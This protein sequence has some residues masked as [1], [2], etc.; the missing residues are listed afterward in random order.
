MPSHSNPYKPKSRAHE[1]AI[2][3]KIIHS[4][5]RW[6]QDPLFWYIE[7]FCGLD[8]LDGKKD[9]KEIAREFLSFK[10]SK[11]SAYEKHKWDGD[12]DPYIQLWDALAKGGEDGLG[13]W[14]GVIAGTGVGKTYWAARTVLWFLDVFPNSVVITSAPKR[15]QLLATLWKEMRNIFP[16][17][18]T[19][20]P[21]ALLQESRLYVDASFKK[22]KDADEKADMVGWGAMA[23]GAG[24]SAG[25]TSATKARGMHAEHMLI[26]LEECN[27]IAEP[28]MNAFE[29]TLTGRHNL[30][31]AMGN[32]NHKGDILDRFCKRKDVKS[33]RISGYDHPNVVTGEEVFMGAVTQKKID[34]DRNKLGEEHPFFRAM[35][36]GITPESG[37]NS[38]IHR[39]WI[40]QCFEEYETSGRNA[41]GVDVGSSP[42]GNTAAVAW[43]RNGVLER[44]DEFHCADVNALGYNLLK[45]EAWLRDNGWASFSIPTFNDYNIK[46]GNICLDNNG[47]GAGT[48]SI[49][50][51]FHC[52]FL[53]PNGPVIKERIPV[54]HAT[55]NPIYDFGNRRAQMFIHLMDCLKQRKIRLCMKGDDAFK[56]RL[57]EELI[58]PTYK[59][60][61]DGKILI[62]AKQDVEKRIGRS[63][64][65][66]DAVMY[67]AFMAINP[68][69]EKRV[70]PPLTT[71]ATNTERAQAPNF[72]GTKE[73]RKKKYK[74]RKELWKNQSGVNPISRF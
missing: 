8:V 67:W 44:L 60:K 69:V 28:V 21:N 66:A 27:G 71:F 25:E 64:N 63:T 5:K 56:E 2:N 39:A 12:T 26:L 33:V 45:D 34:R 32:P 43:G 30:M 61:D 37:T 6:Q 72:Y 10:W 58:A 59:I 13:Q 18:K 36:R 68:N 48:A 3:Q 7:R 15:E 17:F 54:S 40:E 50:N 55:G 22:E 11:F 52:H 9:R 53:A 73:G 46:N 16:R 70:G 29:M 20:R 65:L 38:V 49:L 74:V 47:V 4:W 14:C 57:I 23:Y 51:R 24:S 62:E 35:I 31:L 41:A 42:T 19:I 1:D